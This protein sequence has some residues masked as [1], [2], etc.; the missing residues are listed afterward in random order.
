MT[1]PSARVV[2]TPNWIACFASYLCRN[3]AWGVFHIQLEDS[4][5]KFDVDPN[6]ALQGATAELVE[7]LEI[8]IRYFNQ[9][10]PS[11]RK[12]LGD[13]ARTA[14]EALRPRYHVPH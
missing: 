8:L 3:P 2:L 5:L 11:Q 12:R 7:E 9:L 10:T 6:D 4:N 13:R 1:A 14:V